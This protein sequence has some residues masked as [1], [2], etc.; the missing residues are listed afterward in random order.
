MD[1]YRRDMCLDLALSGIFW[2]EMRKLKF[3]IDLLTQTFSTIGLAKTYESIES[4][5]TLSKSFI[6]A[7]VLLKVLPITIYVL[8]TYMSQVWQI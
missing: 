7:L 8:S 1:G 6:C 2:N 5:L 3:R 4:F